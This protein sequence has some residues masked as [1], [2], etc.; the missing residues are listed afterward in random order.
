MVRSLT[1]LP[2]TDD[3]IARITAQ[4]LVS[5]LR[6]C[7]PD[8]DEQ[9]FR[10]Q[11]PGYSADFFA[12]L[13]QARY[14][15]AMRECTSEA[16]I[17]LFAQ[18]AKSISDHRT[19][20]KDASFL[21]FLA[22]VSRPALLKN[23]N[24]AS[25]R[26]IFA[27]ALKE[28][29]DTLSTN[30]A[31]TDVVLEAA[32][33]LCQLDPSRTMDYLAYIYANPQAA[34]V[35]TRNFYR[36]LSRKTEL[37]R[38]IPGR[39]LR[40]DPDAPPVCREDDQLGALAVGCLHLPLL[41]SSAN[42][43]LLSE[44]YSLELAKAER[45]AV[46]GDSTPESRRARIRAKNDAIARK[47]RIVQWEVMTSVPSDEDTSA[48][49]RQ[50][51]FMPATQ[52]ADI[53]GL[54]SREEILDPFAEKSWKA[55]FNFHLPEAGAPF[56][57]AGADFDAQ[58]ATL[59]GAEAFASYQ[60]AQRGFENLLRRITELFP[61]AHTNVVYSFSKHFEDEQIDFRSR[62]E[63]VED[64]EL[65]FFCLLW[66]LRRQDLEIWQTDPNLERVAEFI[67]DDTTAWKPIA[68]RKLIA[69]LGI[70]AADGS[71][72]ITTA[73]WH[74]LLRWIKATSDRLTT[75]SQDESP[76]KHLPVKW[77]RYSPDEDAWLRELRSAFTNPVLCAF[78]RRDGI[79]RD[80]FPNAE[81]YDT[82]FTLLALFAPVL[83]EHGRTLAD[84]EIITAR[85][86]RVCRAACLPLEYLF[87]AY[88]PAPLS[89]LI[90]ALNA[91]R[92]LSTQGPTGSQDHPALRIM[93]VALGFATIA[94]VMPSITSALDDIALR[95][96]FLS[97]LQPYWSLL[98]SLSTD[99]SLK[100]VQQAAVTTGARE[101]LS[102]FRHEVMKLSAYVLSRYVVRIKDAFDVSPILPLPEDAKRQ[103]AKQKWSAP[104][105]FLTV[106]PDAQ[107]LTIP[108][109]DWKVCPVP[110]TWEHMRNLIAIWGGSRTL[111]TD[112]HVQPIS[113]LADIITAL[114]GIA[115]TSAAI[116]IKLEDDPQLRG[117]ESAE[118][119]E[120]TTVYSLASLSATLNESATM[121]IPIPGGSD[122]TGLDT[123]D[124]SFSERVFFTAG[125]LGNQLEDSAASECLASLVRAIVAGLS[126]AFYHTSGP[127]KL[128]TAGTDTSLVITMTNDTN[129]ERAKK[130]RQSEFW[131]GSQAV[132]EACVRP[133]GGR[134]S[135]NV[136]P[137]SARWVTTI[138][139]PFS[140][141]LGEEFVQWIL[142]EG[143]DK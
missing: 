121:D 73:R 42:G 55:H 59:R 138:E 40:Q 89:V 33:H 80:E 74:S 131:A 108:V 61:T 66:L 136:D 76:A 124:T 31:S 68:F 4:T 22:N 98:T 109:Q 49:E 16:D 20:Q 97:W 56:L 29:F 130:P 95:E 90:L 111:L 41:A 2:H 100:P 81:F 57:R 18:Y 83:D 134:F 129:P 84:P 10:Q 123:A 88:Q 28:T 70:G 93:P 101:T 23:P 24:L 78:L 119:I 102:A 46:E 139:V 52:L 137:T 142:V 92:E 71:R 12:D 19:W 118:E 75:S 47:L 13:T 6:A 132:G 126:N 3:P 50:L 34:K 58:A 72:F 9:A 53:D 104:A 26:R 67:S 38:A 17:S 63:L 36:D 35:R 141:R 39:H 64:G 113:S 69:A 25:E 116:R 128:A 112:L 117:I 87:R 106:T 5:A 143:N 65:T 45:G 37:Y 54:P 32:I 60:E 99:I 133:I 1:L 30:I 51:R 115:Q 110:R 14:I 15:D 94:G 79:Y 127:V 44:D 82:I 43:L 103:D 85:L 91:Q 96:E 122:E 107:R 8:G 140:T 7:R 77:L 11:F 21:A 125:R 27:T 62:A 86:A 114:I 135:L 105:G 48:S 120:T